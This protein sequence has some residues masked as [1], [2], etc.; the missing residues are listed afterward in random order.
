MDK[1]ETQ[2]GTLADMPRRIW[3][4]WMQGRENLPLIPRAC[5]ESWQK[6]NPDW[7]V[8]FLDANNI[9]DYLNQS[10]IPAEKLKA[11]SPQVYANAIRINL[12]RKHGGVWVDATTWCRKPL[13]D[14]LTGMPGDFFAFASPG[15]DRMMANWF[16]AS[17]SGAY[18]ARKMAREYLNIFN[19]LG[20]LKLFPGPMVD[21]ILK[22]AKTTDVFFEPLLIQKLRG[23]P[24][25]LFHYL[26]AYLYR[27]DEA[28]KEAWGQVKKIP[29]APCLAPGFMKLREP[30]DEAAKETLRNADAPM[31][32]LSWRIKEIP[33][34]SLLEDILANRI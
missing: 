22:R 17:A 28:F 3:F 18:L 10:K 13:S 8:V 11:T 15:S 20:P 1:T 2:S 4:H 25:Y 23:Y 34:G 16:M 33:P 26:F 5:L 30:A 12:L 6:M 29:A 31:Y 7:E 21:E 27:R 19:K 9:W 32:K 24:Y 14:W